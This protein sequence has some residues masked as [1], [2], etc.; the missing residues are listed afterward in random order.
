MDWK[1]YAKGATTLPVALGAL[2]MLLWTVVA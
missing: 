1:F 2:A